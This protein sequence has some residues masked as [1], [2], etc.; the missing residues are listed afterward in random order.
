MNIVKIMM[1]V[2]I[3]HVSRD[4]SVGLKAY[5][6]LT[7][8][9]ITTCASTQQ[10]N[11]QVELIHVQSLKNALICQR[12]T[13]VHAQMDFKELVEFVLILTNVYPIHVLSPIP[14]ATI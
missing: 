10:M 2:T 3:V 8:T 1:V 4:T 14:Y 7:L 5:V 6:S 9:V 11:A 12:D 13:N